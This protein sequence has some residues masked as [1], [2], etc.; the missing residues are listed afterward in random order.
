VVFFESMG[1]QAR[2]Q[3]RLSFGG[4][5]PWAVGLILS[6]L[7]A[8]SLLAAFGER[9]LTSFFD[10][11]ALRPAEVW[12]G[13]VWRLATWPFV[14]GSPLGLLFSCLV[15]YWFSPELAQVMGSRRFLTVFGGVM[16]AAAA[17][18][19]L[20]ALVDPDVR[21]HSY[22]GSW[23][24]TAALVVAWGLWFPDRV[25]RMYFILPVRGYW[26]AW[27]TVAI[28]VVYAVYVGWAS[29]LPELLA[30]VSVLAWLFRRTILAR[31]SG[32]RRSLDAGR[33]AATGGRRGVVVDFNPGDRVRR[34]DRD[35]H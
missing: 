2:W 32:V 4:R 7:V 33:R 6:L 12:H 26:V 18:T 28:T 24:L 35:L 20:I 11:L 16:L 34:G 29:L 23:A 3:R 22:L 8:L 10:V 1:A 15:L 27:L 9:H 14:E 13:Q 21:G 25:I 17:G 31:L 30:E 19:C 5:I